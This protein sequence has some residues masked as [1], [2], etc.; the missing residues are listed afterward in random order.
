MCFVKH[1]LPAH[2]H[3]QASSV[4]RED[5]LRRVRLGASI[6][7]YCVLRAPIERRRALM[8]PVVSPWVSCQGVSQPQ[9][10]FFFSF[11]PDVFFE[12][13]PLDDLS[14]QRAALTRSIRKER[15]GNPEDTIEN[16][17][18]KRKSQTNHP[19]SDCV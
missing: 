6:G 1:K 16:K 4:R 17:E 11:F 14:A 10:F 8:H 2:S 15:A 7:Q 9:M 5:G 3:F 12:S 13:W 19:K 18:S